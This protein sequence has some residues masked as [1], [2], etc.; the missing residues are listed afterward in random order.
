MVKT[1]PP[2]I[3]FVEDEPL[4]LELLSR[5]LKEKGFEVH[6]FSC[7]AEAL[8]WF[9]KHSDLVDLLVTDQSMPSFT[10]AQL[11]EHVRTIKEQFPSIIVTGLGKISGTYF[12]TGPTLVLEKPFKRQQLIDAIENLFQENL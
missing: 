12:K 11:I 10:G 7:P 8:G 5:A 1:W 4:A 2:R 6:A 9:E 3:L